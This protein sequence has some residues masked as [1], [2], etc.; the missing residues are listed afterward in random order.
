MFMIV[1]EIHC[2]FFIALPIRLKTCRCNVFPLLYKEKSVNPK[3]RACLS[4]FARPSMP[5]RH[6]ARICPDL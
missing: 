1:F 5:D 4:G 3:N 2:T 6:R